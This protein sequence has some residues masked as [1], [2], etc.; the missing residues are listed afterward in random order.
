MVVPSSFV[1]SMERQGRGGEEGR[2][3]PKSGGPASPKARRCSLISAAQKGRRRPKP[4]NLQRAHQHQRG[5]RESWAA[6]R[7]RAAAVTAR[8]GREAGGMGGQMRSLGIQRSLGVDGN[9]GTGIPNACQTIIA[10]I[11]Y[12]SVLSLS[13]STFSSEERIECSFPFWRLLVLF[14]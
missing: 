11:N 9:T 8:A 7:A 2:A 6:A 5:G 14:S 1:R 10:T 13:G 4:D 12:F 3:Q